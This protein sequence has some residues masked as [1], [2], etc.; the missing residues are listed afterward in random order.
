M[1]PKSIR[2]IFLGTPGFAACSLEKLLTEKYNVVAVVTAPDKPS[3]R[4]LQ[5][6]QS[7]VKQLAVKYNIPVLQPEKL[8]SPEFIEELK[9]FDPELMIVVAFRMLPEVVWSMPKHGTFNLHGS[10][11]PH[12][13]GAAPINRA[14]MNGETKTGVTTF[15]LKQEIDTGNIIF[16]EEI[17]IGE[18]E[19]AGELH[20]RMMVIG[21]ALVTKTVDAIA[22]GNAHPQDQQTFVQEGE[23][24]KDAP[25]LFRDNTKINWQLPGKQIVDHIRGLNP[26]PAA[27]TEL[28]HGTERIPMKVYKAEFMRGNKSGTTGSSNGK[29]EVQVADGTIA[30]KEIQ[31]PGKKRMSTDE[32]LRGFR[33]NAEMKFE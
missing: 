10:L 11:L 3:G 30:L 16:R 12:Y 19:T 9:R 15:L 17:P 7:E 14:I 33:I 22:T 24:L 4:G 8:K 23:L 2:I 32:F 28:I 31:A 21:A 13:R 1:E 6:Q 5:M 27:W 18:N 26:F 20:D 25:K 29:L